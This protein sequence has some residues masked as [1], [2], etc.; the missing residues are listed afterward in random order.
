MISAD[1]SHK[2]AIY[3]LIK[4]SKIYQI[5]TAKE[6]QVNI[7]GYHDEWKRHDAENYVCDLNLANDI[8]I[9]IVICMHKHNNER[10]C[11]TIYIF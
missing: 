9:S 4:L 2:K 8:C 3:R 7:L 10:K 1:N 5:T 6:I 11:Q